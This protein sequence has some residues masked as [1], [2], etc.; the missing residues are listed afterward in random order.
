MASDRA[1]RRPQARLARDDRR[2]RG[3]ERCGRSGQ[4]GGQSPGHGLGSH[5]DRRHRPGGLLRLPGHPAGDG[6]DRGPDRPAGLADHPALRGQPGRH[7]PGRGPGA[8]YRAQHALAGF[9]ERAG[10]RRSPISAR[11]GG[12]AR[13]A[14]GRFAAHP[15]GAGRGGRLRPGA[16]RRAARRAGRL[17][18]PDRDRRRAAARLRPGRHPGGVAVG[19]GAALRGPAAQPEGHPGPAARR[20]GR[21]GRLAAAGRPA[22]GGPGLGAR[23]GRAGRAGHRGG[24]LRAHP[25]RGQ[26]RDRP[27]RGQRRRDRPRVRA[28]PAPRGVTQASPARCARSGGQG[29]AG[30]SSGGYGCTPVWS[31]RSTRCLVAVYL[32]RGQPLRQLG[33]QRPG[34]PARP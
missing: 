23:R 16:G 15:A 14:A 20:G 18:G 31:S 7:R 25:G 34:R 29:T 1:E 30:Q 4:R 33:G 28:L 11:D 21:A 32:V 17:Q 19:R 10:H 2:L 26:G 24:R 6:G 3:L 13:R 22:A 8:R 27:A 5:P 9:T 12:A